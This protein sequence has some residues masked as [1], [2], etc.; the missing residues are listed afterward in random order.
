MR[1]P[2]FSPAFWVVFLDLLW[3]CK[4]IM[5]FYTVIQP[6]TNRS[7]GKFCGELTKRGKWCCCC[8]PRNSSSCVQ[9]SG[10]GPP[11][12]K[13]VEG[14]NVLF[15]AALGCRS[16]IQYVVILS[17]YCQLL[18]FYSTLQKTSF[19]NSICWWMLVDC[20]TCKPWI[21]DDSTQSMACIPFY[22]E[23]VKHMWCVV[24]STCGVWW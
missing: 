12:V 9:A 8:L 6:W 17:Q 14:W 11:Y 19:R 7:S 16:T 24:V 22:Q 3:L 20:Y 10:F 15:E 1:S 13:W 21:C 4:M 18:H 23:F 2:C 5:S